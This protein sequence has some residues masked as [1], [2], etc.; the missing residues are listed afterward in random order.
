MAGIGR[1]GSI[2]IGICPCHHD[3][4]SYVTTIASGAGSVFNNGLAVALVGSIGISSCGHPTTALTGSGTVDATGI[5]LHRVGDTGQN[6]GMYTL[7]SG[8]GDTNNSL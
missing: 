3:P 8:S 7:I 6:C 1:V 5:P 4:V 2:G